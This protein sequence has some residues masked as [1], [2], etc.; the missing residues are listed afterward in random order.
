MKFNLIHLWWVILGIASAG[1][2][3]TLFSQRDAKPEHSQK[4]TYAHPQEYM[5]GVSVFSYTDEGLLKHHLSADYWAYIPEQQ[6]SELTTPHLTVY[7]PDNTIWTIDA[8]K[9]NVTQP[10][11]GQIEQVELSDSVILKR[12]PSANLMPIT[13]ETE[14]LRYQPKKQYAETDQ[15]ITLIKPDLTITG[16][17]M[18]AY[19]NKNTVELL[20]N[21]KSQFIS[22]PQ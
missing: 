6:E 14:V 18:R 19:L 12:P 3:F 22:K 13:L 9:G 20:N 5:K 11:I 1:L 10:S 16:V 15:A 8:K 21:V 4:I 17:G 2:I 7:K